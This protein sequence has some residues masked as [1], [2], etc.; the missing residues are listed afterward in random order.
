MPGMSSSP[1]RQSA[2]APTPGSTTRSARATLSGS[3]VTTIGWSCAALARGALEGFG[4]RVQIAGAVIDDGDAHRE[5][6][7]SGNRP[8][9]SGCARPRRIGVAHW[10]GLRQRRRRGCALDPFARRSAA[11]R[12]RGPRRSTKPS[13]LQR[14]PRQRP[15]PDRRRLEAD[16]QRDDAGRRGIAPCRTRRAD[17]SPTATA[18]LTT[19][20]EQ[21][22]QPQPM[23]Q[24]PQRRQQER[25]EIKSVA[26][27]HEA[28]ADR[29]RSGLRGGGACT[30]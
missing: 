5:P 3:L 7:G 9:T 29:W 18:P 2:K 19:I 1:R 4:R 20:I 8:I 30:V 21:Q 25:P 14:A 22:R 28:L 26:H 23:Q 13:V 27:E 10:R 17:V 11:R 12:F 16:E 24:Q 15:A 6:P